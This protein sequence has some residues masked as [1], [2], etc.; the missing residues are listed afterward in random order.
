MASIEAKILALSATEFW[1]LTTVVIA[2]ALWSL[3]KMALNYWAARTIESVPTA[4]IRSAA[5]GY[6][7]LIGDT[8]LMEGPVIVSPLSGKTCVWFRYIIE[9]RRTVNTKNGRRTRW[10][11]I[12]EQVS[13]ELFLLKDATGQCVIDPE[14]ADVITDNKH[15]WNST[16]AFPKR[17]YTEWIIN[18]YERVYAIGLFKSITHIERQKMR[19]QVSDLLRDW[20]KNTPNKLIH[21]YDTNRDGEVDIHEWQ[22]VRAAA[23]QQIKQQN[24]DFGS[25]NL[26]TQSPHSNQQFILS[27]LPESDLI[28]RYKK[29]ALLTLFGFITAGSLLV[30]AINV[31]LG[32]N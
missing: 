7:E 23:E 20:K 30:W 10:V 24:Q 1:L 9:E 8:E 14:G 6:V 17:R 32:F 21:L 15:Q 11:K 31:R 29:R 18:Q 22:Q 16:S 19:E 28:N 27:T 25:L 4:K 5:Q 2:L 13:D 26:L 3:R 12:K